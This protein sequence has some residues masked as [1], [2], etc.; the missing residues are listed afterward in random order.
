[1]WCRCP[2]HGNCLQA[3]KLK[4][5][6]V[7]DTSSDRRIL[8]L[9]LQDLGLIKDVLSGKMPF[10]ALWTAEHLNEAYRDF[11]QLMRAED[12]ARSWDNAPESQACGCLLVKQHFVM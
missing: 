2:Q 6:R 9:A 4:P 8:E 12:K 3:R 11:L 5:A 1:M 10:E 7:R